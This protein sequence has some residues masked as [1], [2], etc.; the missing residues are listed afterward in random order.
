VI[1]EENSGLANAVSIE[2]LSDLIGSAEFQAMVRNALEIERT[3][4][5]NQGTQRPI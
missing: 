4:A 5:E 3:Q 2:A 1:F